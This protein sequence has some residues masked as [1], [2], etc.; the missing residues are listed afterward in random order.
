ME[1]VTFNSEGFACAAYLGMPEQT[2]H[3]PCP[4]IVLGHGFGALKESL[5]LEAKHLTAAGYV[6]LAI[7]YR[8]FG[9]SEGEPRG[10]LYPFNE[11]EDFRNAITYLQQRAG[12]DPDRIGAW[13]CSFG[14]GVAIMTAALDR[15]VRAVVAVAPVVNGRRWLS[16]MWGGDRFEQL[17]QIVEADRLCRYETG[18]GGR[19]PLIGPELPAAI[20]MD[21]RGADQ[22][23]RIGVQ[24]GRP[25]VPGAAD[26]TIASLEKIMEWAPDAFIDRIAP[27]ALLI[28]TPGRW[29]MMHP[30]DQIQDAFA[31]AGEPKRVIPVNCEQNE[32]YVDPWLTR[33]LN[34][35]IDWY[36]DHLLPNES[37]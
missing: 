20:T 22:Y 34:H 6:T 24:E 14:G 9:E 33:S 27:R 26:L 29:D 31:R 2:A 19:I 21:Q 28:V 1:K 12:V 25:M 10:S 5:L 37:S 3:G 15:R 23:A 16:A 32:I 7:D 36:K 4:A 11:V 18:E 8:S 13:G 17:R 35:A 30:Y